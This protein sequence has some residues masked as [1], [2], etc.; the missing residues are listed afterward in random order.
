MRSF[1]RTFSSTTSA[2][3]KILNQRRKV[4]LKFWNYHLKTDGNY[5][6]I[7]FFTLLVMVDLISRIRASWK[8]RRQQFL[9]SSENLR[10]L[11]NSVKCF[12]DIRNFLRVAEIENIW[13]LCRRYGNFLNPAKSLNLIEIPVCNLSIIFW[14]SSTPLVSGIL[15]TSLKTNQNLWIFEIFGTF[16]ESHQAFGI[17][18]TSC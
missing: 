2:K 12:Y 15:A 5:R 4:Q 17:F 6:G 7:Y 10:N 13:N 18:G 11:I 9:E 1:Y 8:A 16:P 14:I 3:L